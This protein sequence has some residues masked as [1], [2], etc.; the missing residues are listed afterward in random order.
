[1]ASLFVRGVDDTLIERL[2]KQAAAHGRSTE[3][4][5]RAILVAAL[6]GPRKRTFA[7]VLKAMPNVGR[8]ED[9]A[10]REASREPTR[11]VD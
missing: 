9:F 10:R 11:E 1:M 7:Q 2:R 4:E 6:R 3:A 5:H 8:D